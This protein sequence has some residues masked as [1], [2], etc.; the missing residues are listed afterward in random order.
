MNKLF[1]FL[2][3]LVD[4]AVIVMLGSIPLIILIAQIQSLK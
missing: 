4:Y 2:D 1:D 3:K